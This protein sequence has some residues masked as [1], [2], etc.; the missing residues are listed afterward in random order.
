M[1]A[2]SLQQRPA[3]RSGRLVKGSIA[4]PW[5]LP[6]FSSAPRRVCGRA[7]GPRGAACVPSYLTPTTLKLSWC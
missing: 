6:F 2:G 1:V 7:L 5:A 4:A 3:P